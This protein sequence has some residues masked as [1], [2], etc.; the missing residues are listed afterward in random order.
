MTL[1]SRNSIKFYFH[2]IQIPSHPTT[3]LS[4]KILSIPQMTCYQESPKL[5]FYHSQLLLY[6]HQMSHIKK[7][8]T[9]YKK[10]IIIP[11]KLSFSGLLHFSSLKVEVGFEVR[12]FLESPKRERTKH[13]RGHHSDWS[14]TFEPV[15]WGCLPRPSIQFCFEESTGTPV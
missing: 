9:H 5:F 12:E 13:K 2:Q 3:S 1:L 6:N 7:L 4:I 10:K 8:L 15:F 14:Q 11:L